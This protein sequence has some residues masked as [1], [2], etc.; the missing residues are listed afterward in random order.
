MSQSAG[1]ILEGLTGV[2]VPPEEDMRRGR[3]GRLLGD[4]VVEMAVSESFPES[5]VMTPLSEENSSI[6]SDAFLI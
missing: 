3:L 6:S 2:V 1:T 5:G 4:S